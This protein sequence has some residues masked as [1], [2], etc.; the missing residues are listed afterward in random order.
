MPQ[1]LHVA[2][3]VEKGIGIAPATCTLISPSWISYKEKML[4]IRTDRELIAATLDGKRECFEEVV[5][6][7]EDSLY[8]FLSRR[9]SQ[10]DAFDVVQET[11]LQAWKCLG[12]Y[13]PQWEFSTWLYSIAYRLSAGVYRQRKRDVLHGASR[14]AEVLCQVPRE[15]LPEA[16]ATLLNGKSPE[17]VW[18]IAREVLPVPQMSALW[19]FYVEDK[20]VREIA[21]IMRRTEVGVKTLL[22]RGRKKLQRYL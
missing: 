5:R 11:F 7:H 19:M 6:R 10:E 3:C 15:E 14:S 4:M 21:Q 17:N 13:N 8:R 2:Q 9:H 20:S 12:N 22:F 18:D 16:G 1:S